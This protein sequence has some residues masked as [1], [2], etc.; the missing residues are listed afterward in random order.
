VEPDSPSSIAEATVRVLSDRELATRLAQK[1][2]EKAKVYSWENAAR[3]TLETYQ[4]AERESRY[5]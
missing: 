3:R 5:E 4:E 1:G 2:R